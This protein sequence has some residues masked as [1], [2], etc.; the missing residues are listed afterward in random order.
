MNV[1]TN[2]SLRE[3]ERVFVFKVAGIKMANLCA[4]VCDVTNY[5]TANTH[6]HVLLLKLHNKSTTITWKNFINPPELQYF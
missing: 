6:A 1:A 4:V 2:V 3:D 5:G